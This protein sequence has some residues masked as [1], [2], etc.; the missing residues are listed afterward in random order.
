MLVKAQLASIEDVMAKPK[1][2]RQSEHLNFSFLQD[3]L[4]CGGNCDIVKDPRRPDRWRPVYVCREGETFEKRGLKEAIFEACEK[5][6]MPN[7]K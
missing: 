3:C 2:P 7:L 5:E 6:R 1:R 4:F